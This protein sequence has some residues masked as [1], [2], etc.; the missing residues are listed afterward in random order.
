MANKFIRYDHAAQI[1]Y[2]RL[3]TLIAQHRTEGTRFLMFGSGMPANMAI[4]YLKIHGIKVEAILDNNQAKQ[5]GTEYGT[6]IYSPEDYLAKFDKKIR[7]M[8]ASSHEDAMTAQI[9]KLGYG[10]EQIVKLL[11]FQKATNDYSFADRTGYRELNRE[12]IRERQMRLLRHLKE[13]CDRH[14]LRYWLCYGTLLGAVRHHG[15]IP[16]DDDIDVFV[17]WKDLKKL[18]KIIQEEP[19]YG[20]ATFINNEMDFCDSCSYMYEMESDM[21]VNYFPMQASLG[22]NIDIFPLMGVPGDEKEKQQYI[23]DMKRLHENV[24]NKMYSRDELQK[25]TAELIAYIDKY[26]FDTCADCGYVIGYYFTQEIWSAD[27]FHKAMEMPF[28][29][30]NFRVPSGWKTYLESLYGKDYM[31]PPPESERIPLHNFKAYIRETGGAR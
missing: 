7:I 19:D 31:T 21:E 23:A 6:P 11:E 22:M 16:W 28:E 1:F 15:Y 26:D 29:G 8:I 10:E 5:G 9:K 18:V 24:W 20:I 2:K 13:L 17:E 14:G 25:A 3:D 12:E 30:E 27:S 4:Y